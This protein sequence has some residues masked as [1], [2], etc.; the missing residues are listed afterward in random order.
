MEMRCCKVF[1]DKKNH[2]PHEYEYVYEFLGFVFVGLVYHGTLSKTWGKYLSMDEYTLKNMGKHS[3]TDEYPLQS[4]GKHSSG[5]IN[6]L[7]KAWGKQ[8]SADG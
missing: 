2:T 5:R 3:N 7:S 4:M 6:T 1:F 8:S